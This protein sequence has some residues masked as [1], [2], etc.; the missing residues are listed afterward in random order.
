MNLIRVMPAEGNMHSKRNALVV[1]LAILACAYVSTART[2]DSTRTVLTEG[3]VVNAIRAGDEAPISK[4]T[5][6]SVQIRR[7]MQGQDAEYILELT[8]PSIIAYSES[9]TNVSNYGSFR[10]RGIDQTRVNVTWNGVPLND[11]ID[12][13]VFFSNI[14]DL[15]N[16]VHSVQVQRGVG[17]SS[18]G[19]ASFA[20]SVNIE[21]G[22]IARV[23]P[24]A[25]VQLSGGSFD[26]WRASAEASTGRM[27]GNTSVSAR[28][29]TFKTDGYRNNTATDSWSASMSAAA[30]SEDDIFKLSAV[31]GRTKNELGYYAV[32]LPLY[33]QDRKTNINEVT[34]H[35]DFGQGV[36][37]AQWSHSFDTTFIGSLQLYYGH[38]GGDYFSGYREANNMLVQLNYPLT[39]DHVGGI[40]TV[41]SHGIAEGLDI[42][43]G[44]HVYTFGRHN[45]EYVT[46]ESNAPYYDDR[47][48]KNEISAF[49][50]GQQTFGDLHAFADVQVRSVGMSFNPDERYIPENTSIP[51]HTWLFVNPRIGASYDLSTSLDV[52]ASFGRTGREPTRFDLLGSTQISE[53]NL[54]VLLNVNTV[55]P[56]FVNDIEAGIRYR[57]ADLSFDV[58]VFNMQF[59]DE[60]A[61]IGQYIEQGFVQL[62][63]NIP[64]SRRTGVELEAMVKIIDELRLSANATYMNARIAEYAPDNM[65]TD[66]VYSNVQPVL[67]PKFMGSLSLIYTPIAS[68]DLQINARYVGSSF[69]ELT[70]GQAFEQSG[71][72][73]DFTL[74]SFTLLNAHI[75]WNFLLQHSIVFTANNILG[76]EYA[77]NGATGFYNGETVPTL[78]AQAKRSFSVMLDLAF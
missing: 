77:T 5:I 35:D 22:Q 70:N 68:L 64:S 73:S 45:W 25:R 43:G 53:S 66:T 30:Y 63:K 31:I 33:E 51:R 15:M 72:A 75:A 58:N 6:D 60:I 27:T 9:G 4:T 69:L 3:V 23:R 74:K 12:Q 59:T 39:N 71:T 32:P 42:T 44:I 54:D 10:L 41:E 56:E 46:P 78:F 61:P 50:K 76:A 52:F 67:T 19:T 49:V 20:G 11:M 14:T 1:A 29:T 65:G 26:L 24:S 8:A 34:D 37:Q 21:G 57:T 55:R 2:K 7:V 28:F 13:G 40:I 16:G 48:R 38:A 62:R 36:V 47:T 17:T 18:N